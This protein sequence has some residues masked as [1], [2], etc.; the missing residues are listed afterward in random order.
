[1]KERYDAHKK[2]KAKQEQWQIS[3]GPKGEADEESSGSYLIEI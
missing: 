1:M 2:L 3:T